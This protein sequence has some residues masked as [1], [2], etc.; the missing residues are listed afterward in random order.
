MPTRPSSSRA[1]QVGTTHRQSLLPGSLRGTCL[2]WPDMASMCVGLP[3]LHS[4]VVNS[5][6]LVLLLSQSSTWSGETFSPASFPAH[7]ICTSLKLQSS[8]PV[9]KSFIFKMKLD[10]I[11]P[12]FP[13]ERITWFALRKKGIP[14]LAC[15]SPA[16]CPQP[17]ESLLGRL[18]GSFQ[19]DV[20]CHLASSNML[21]LNIL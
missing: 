17:A 18:D 7:S 11:T 21:G 6:A 5:A 8:A 1:M 10:G 13:G 16:N 2:S 4:S 12:P 19:I 20:D 3:R 9:C 15:A 14:S